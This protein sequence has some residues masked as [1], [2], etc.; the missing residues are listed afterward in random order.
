MTF[1]VLN[2]CNQFF[3]FV[4]TSKYVV[5]IALLSVCVYV[6]VHQMNN[7]NFRSIFILLHFYSGV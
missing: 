1:I 3:S 4:I 7:I 2:N 5:D 6:H